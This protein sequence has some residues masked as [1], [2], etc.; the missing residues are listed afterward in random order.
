MSDVHKSFQLLAVYTRCC[1]TPRHKVDNSSFDEASESGSSKEVSA[2]HGFISKYDSTHTSDLEK[3]RGGEDRA[4]EHGWRV[5]VI[6]LW[7]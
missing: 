3:R 1:A 6:K 5:S 2:H 4:V 7:A